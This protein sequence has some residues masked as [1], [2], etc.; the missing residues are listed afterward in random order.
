MVLSEPIVLKKCVGLLTP[1]EILL[2]R[3]GDLAIA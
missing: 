1:I 2:E 3:E